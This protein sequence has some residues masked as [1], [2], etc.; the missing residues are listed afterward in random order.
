MKFQEE[1]NGLKDYHNLVLSVAWL[2]LIFTPRR[3]AKT[4]H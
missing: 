1:T 4:T 2:E 3:D